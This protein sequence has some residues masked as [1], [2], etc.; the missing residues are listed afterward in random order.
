[1]NRKV[2]AV[3]YSDI[4]RCSKQKR[5]HIQLMAGLG[6]KSDAHMGATV[7]QRS[8]VAQNPTQHRFLH[9][10]GRVFNALA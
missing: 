1:M 6:V 3:G 7:K 10:E 8:H 5:E 4:H 2:L 9:V